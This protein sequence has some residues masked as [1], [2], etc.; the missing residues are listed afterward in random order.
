VEV[1]D[2]LTLTSPVALDPATVNAT[3]ITLRTLPTPPA[4]GSTAVALYP[5]RPGKRSII[6]QGRLARS[7]RAV[8][9]PTPAPRSPPTTPR[10]RASSTPSADSS[11]P[12]TTTFRTKD[13]NRSTT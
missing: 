7:R 3:N 10:D 9:P 5:L 12:P 1:N 4:T 11:P 8:H 6:P 13:D 2:L